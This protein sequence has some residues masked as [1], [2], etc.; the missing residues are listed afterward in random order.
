METKKFALDEAITVLGVNI[1]YAT[2]RTLC[3]LLNKNIS[4]FPGE[5]I[6]ITDLLSVDIEFQ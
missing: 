2:K 6:T 1:K 5:E 4:N 3:F